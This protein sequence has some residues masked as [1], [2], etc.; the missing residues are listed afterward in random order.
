MKKVSD[1]EI[2]GASYSS[3]ANKCTNSYCHGGFAFSKASS[4]Y[5]F[6]YTADKI[7]GNNYQ[8]L[9]NKVDGTQMACGTCHGLPPTGH[10]SSDLKS[11]ATCHTGIVDKYGKIIDASKH[12]DGKI[13]VFGN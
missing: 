3:T 10:V 6:A 9:W 11:C 12:M 2:G 5:Q 13:N 8:P 7:E 4:Q 1:Y